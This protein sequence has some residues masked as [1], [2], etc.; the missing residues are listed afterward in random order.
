[1]I[2]GLGLLEDLLVVGQG[3]QVLTPVEM[4]L[5]LVHLP[6]SIV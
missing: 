4:S 5:G 1:M 2:A 3:L 6:R